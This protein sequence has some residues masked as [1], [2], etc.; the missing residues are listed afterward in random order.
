MEEM[1][2]VWLHE[3]T[4]GLYIVVTDALLESDAT[5]NMVVYKSLVSGQCWVRPASEFHD[6]RFQLLPARDCEVR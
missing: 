1:S 2:E 5:T 6:G 3:K 4:G